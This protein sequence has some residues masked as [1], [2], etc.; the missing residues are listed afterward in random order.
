MYRVVSE[1]AGRLNT[2]ILVWGL[3]WVKR[4]FCTVKIYHIQE[5]LFSKKTPL[6][7]LLKNHFWSYRWLLLKCLIT[8]A[9]NVWRRSSCPEESRVTWSSHV[10]RRVICQGTV[11]M[12]HAHVYSLV[13]ELWCWECVLGM[14]A[15]EDTEKML[16]KKRKEDAHCSFFKVR[17]GGYSGA[18]Y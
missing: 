3:A 2:L 11:S 14:C 5:L 1:E 17:R 7:Y 9:V 10:C 8:S 16:I 6:P 13:S 12:S 4:P 15:N 18:V